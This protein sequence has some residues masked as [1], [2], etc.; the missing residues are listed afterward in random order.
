MTKPF[1]KEGLANHGIDVVVPSDEDQAY[2]VKVIFDELTIGKLTDE[3]RAGY[4]KIIDKLVGPRASSLVAPRYRCS[5]GRMI[6]R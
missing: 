5:S 2:I 1:Y 6:R 4:L 3:S